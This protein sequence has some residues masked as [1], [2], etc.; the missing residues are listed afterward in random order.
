MIEEKIFALLSA[1]FGGRVYPDIAPFG[2]ETPYCTYQQI[3]GDVINTLSGDAPDKQNGI[4]Q[5]NIWAATR[6]QASLLAK[7][8]EDAFRSAAAMQAKPESAPVAQHEP[9]LNLYGTRQ[10]FNIWSDR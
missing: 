8:T 3:G 4:F 7:L 1:M 10:D 9:D 2:T 5:I 6:L